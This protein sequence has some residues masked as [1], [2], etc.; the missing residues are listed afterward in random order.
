MAFSDQSWEHRFGQMGDASEAKFVE[1]CDGKC[2]RWGI[3]RPEGVYVPHLPARV[4]AAPDYLT[5][6]GYVECMGLGR[7]QVLQLKLEKLNVLHWWH[8]LMPV[9]VFVWDSYKKRYGIIGL[10]ELDRLINT[11]DLCEIVYFDGRKLT[12]CVPADSIFD[13]ADDVS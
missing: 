7:K 2:E 8:N 3:N 13:A 11:P 9:R 6:D 4:R 5:D 1:Y 12:F 10:M